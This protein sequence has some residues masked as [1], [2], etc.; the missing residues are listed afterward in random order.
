MKYIVS[1]TR[2]G[3]GGLDLEVEA[4]SEDYAKQFALDQAGGESFSEHHSE[5][6]VDRVLF[7]HNTHSIRQIGSDHLL[8]TAIKLLDDEYGINGD[9]Y[10]AMMEAGM[11]PDDIAMRVKAVEGRYYLPSVREL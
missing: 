4:D 11:I 7:A 2:I 3:Y 10:D 5:Y 8:Q 6:Q 1:V 9:A